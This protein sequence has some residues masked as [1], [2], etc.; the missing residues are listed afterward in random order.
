MTRIWIRISN[1]PRRRQCAEDGAAHAV[2]ALRG[3][4]PRLVGEGRPQREAVREGEGGVEAGGGGGDVDVAGG[5][6]TYHSYFTLFTYVST[7]VTPSSL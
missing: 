5:D 6:Y 4:P 2:A 3:I 1:H 7:L